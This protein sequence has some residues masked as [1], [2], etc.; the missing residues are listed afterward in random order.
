MGRYF[1]F[2]AVASL[3]PVAISFADLISTRTVRKKCKFV[4]GF[5]STLFC[6]TIAFLDATSLHAS[7]S[8]SAYPDVTR[9]VA[10]H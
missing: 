4:F 5:I 8:I 2:V 6:R 7:I 10:K 1:A 9:S 3:H